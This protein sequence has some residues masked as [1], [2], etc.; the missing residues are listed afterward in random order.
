MLIV[1]RWVD[2]L[3]LAD[4]TY[5][6][7]P[8]IFPHWALLANVCCELWHPRYCV[9]SCWGLK[10]AS[11]AL[12]PVPD[13]CPELKTKNEREKRCSGPG[14]RSS[15]SHQERQLPGPRRRMAVLIS[16]LKPVLEYNP[17]DDCV[18]TVSLPACIGILPQRAKQSPCNLV[19]HHHHRHILLTLVHDRSAPQTTAAG[20][21]ATK[22]L[23]SLLHP[24]KLTARD[25][26]N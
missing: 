16:Y 19:A 21:R 8:S 3:R 23:A 5:P 1:K 13:R 25:P 2:G 4:R 9:P 17:V 11:L 12:Q 14:R 6:N 22:A 20:R 26:Q 18:L 10:T 15:S 24:C 7:L